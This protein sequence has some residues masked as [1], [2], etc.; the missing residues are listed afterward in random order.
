MNRMIAIAG[1]VFRI[2]GFLSR[3]ECLRLRAI[4]EGIGFEAAGVGAAQ[5]RL[6][7]VRNNDRIVLQSPDWSAQL[8]TRLIGYGLP[9]F[10]GEHAAGFTEYWRFYR[11]TPG[12]RF[13][14]HR[15]GSAESHGM[16][17]RLT[18]LIYLNSDFAGGETRFRPTHAD[19]AP[20]ALSVRP[21]AGMALLFAH[22]R[23]HEGAPVL[24]G[25]K[26]AL[27]TDILYA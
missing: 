13:K 27:R 5:Q 11:Y 20:D 16:R 6:E 12:Q 9:D 7:A 17:S 8:W 21:D 24:D 26:Y 15:D 19:S 3:D 22:E 4:A 1:D 25:V 18:F 14:M 2:P 10:E 23:W